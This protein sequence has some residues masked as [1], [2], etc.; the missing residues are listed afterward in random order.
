MAHPADDG[1]RP[2][3]HHHTS[4]F[5]GGASKS[6]SATVTRQ[7]QVD[8]LIAAA[9]VPPSAIKPWCAP[10]TAYRQTLRFVTATVEPPDRY[11]LEDE[12][13]KLAPD[14]L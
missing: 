14:R 3:A 8:P 2:A 4:P 11:R 10:P 5:W 1:R 6:T 13:L 9:T 12:T 7:R